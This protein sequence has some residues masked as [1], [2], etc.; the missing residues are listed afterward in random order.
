MSIAAS[1]KRLVLHAS[2]L[3]L[4]PSHTPSRLA[5]ASLHV[6]PRSPFSS[7]AIM[8]DNAESKLF[9]DEVTGEMVSKSCVGNVIVMVC[10][11]IEL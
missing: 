8:A 5:V 10:M 9:K 1:V 7:C 4:T 2:R 11:L 3:P 6:P